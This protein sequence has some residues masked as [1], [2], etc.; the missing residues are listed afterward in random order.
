MQE[1][2]DEQQQP[3]VYQARGR[4]LFA[5]DYALS[6]VQ[7]LQ[8]VLGTA[9]KQPGGVLRRTLEHE[10]VVGFGTHVS[11]HA[12]PHSNASSGQ[13]RWMMFYAAAPSVTALALS[14]D[15]LSWTK[16]QP[17]LPL[18]FGECEESD[19]VELPNGTLFFMHRA[20]SC[21]KTGPNCGTGGGPAENHIQSLVG[22]HQRKCQ[23]D[24]H[25]AG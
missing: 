22:S 10:L 4:Q 20:V 19:M 18:K 23:G 13:Q 25:R 12:M 2:A 8:R 9:L 7:G 21:P 6:T 1:R 3:P 15:G 5:D 14:P 17:T 16:P 24:V 11:V